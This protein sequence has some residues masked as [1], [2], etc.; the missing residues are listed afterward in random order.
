MTSDDMEDELIDVV[1]GNKAVKQ[2]KRMKTKS[3]HQNFFS[4]NQKN[5]SSPEKCHGIFLFVDTYPVSIHRF[6]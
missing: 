2:T 6:F 3:Q 1:P 5:Q 4:K